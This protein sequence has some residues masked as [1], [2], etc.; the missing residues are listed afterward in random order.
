MH[1]PL[2]VPRRWLETVH[3]RQYHEAFAR[4]TLDRQAQRRIGLPATTPLVQRTWLAVGGTLLTARLALEHGVACHLAGGTHHAFPDYGSGFCIFNDIAVSARVLL[5]EGRL[6]AL[7]DCGSGCAS[8]RC[9][10]ADLC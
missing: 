4:G 9:H 1:A 7:D 5:E 6:D 3:L 2:P 10:G 8:R